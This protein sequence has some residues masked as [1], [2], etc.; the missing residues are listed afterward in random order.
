MTFLNDLWKKFKT[1][2]TTKEWETVITQKSPELPE[3]PNNVSKTFSNPTA[4]PT[5]TL[6]SDQNPKPNLSEALQQTSVAYH[7][8]E[9]EY[10]QS[11]QVLNNLKALKE[12]LEQPKEEMPELR[13]TKINQHLGDPE[14]HETVRQDRWPENIRCPSCHSTQLKRLAQLP[15]KSSLNHRYHCLA[16]GLEFNDD[17]GTPLEK[18]VPPLNIWMQCWYLMGCTDSLSYI[19][20]KL[21]LDISMVEV[22]ARQLRKIFNAQKPLTHFLE[23][24]EWNKQAVQLRKQLKDDLLKQYELLDANV[25]TTPKDTTEFRRQ[26][27]LRRTLSSSASTEPPSVTPGKKRF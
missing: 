4:N 3:S 19:A 12:I 1:P 2:V 21:N 22:M 9:K 23:F 5:S 6:T 7:N 13:F 17:S 8:T 25:A 27:N 16:C 14:C 18:G 26:Q 24:D 15:P 10:L 11:E 20:I